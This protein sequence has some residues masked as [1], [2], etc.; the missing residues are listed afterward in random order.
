[1]IR[2]GQEK[3][4]SASGKGSNRVRG[5]CQE[6]TCALRGLRVIPCDWVTMWEVGDKRLQGLREWAVP[7][8]S[9]APILVW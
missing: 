7:P 9:G 5:G 8:E 3:G 6:T 1:M 2:V 4:D